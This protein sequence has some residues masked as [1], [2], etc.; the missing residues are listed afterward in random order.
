MKGDKQMIMNEEAKEALESK[1]KELRNVSRIVSN[2]TN[3]LNDMEI[4]GAYSGPMAEV[5]GWLLELQNGLT[6]Q[7]EPLQAQIPQASQTAPKMGE[8]KEAQLV[9][10]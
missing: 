7:I 9:Q 10:G 5:L 8:V 6:K 2:A 4:K 3:L 1:L